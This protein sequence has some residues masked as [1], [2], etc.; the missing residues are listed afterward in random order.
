[1]RVCE[2]PYLRAA[3]LV[4][5]IIAPS[6][7]INTANSSV[8]F[9]SDRTH[10][11]YSAG[12]S[13]APDADLSSTHSVLNK[14]Y[15]TK[16]YLNGFEPDDYRIG[17]LNELQ[18]DINELSRLTI[19]N[20][21]NLKDLPTIGTVSSKEVEKALTIAINYSGVSE[22]EYYYLYLYAHKYQFPNE[23]WG[24]LSGSGGL[25]HGQPGLA[26]RILDEAL[27]VQNRGYSYSGA[28][29]QWTHSFR[30]SLG[31][32]WLFERFLRT[33]NNPKTIGK[34]TPY[35]YPFLYK[36][37]SPSQPMY[38]NKG[39]TI[40]DFPGPGLVV[41][42]IHSPV[43]P[44]G[45][46]A[47]RFGK[48]SK[49]GDI[50]SMVDS[51]YR[52]RIISGAEKMGQTTF[53]FFR[54]GALVSNQQLMKV[55]GNP[56]TLV[57]FND[58]FPV[59]DHHKV[60]CLVDSTMVKHFLH[61]PY[62]FIGDSNLLNPTTMDFKPELRGKVINLFSLAGTAGLCEEVPGYTKDWE[63]GKRIR[64]H[65]QVELAAISGFTQ[66]DL[67]REA[68]RLYL[69]G[70]YYKKEKDNFYRDEYVLLKELLRI[71][72]KMT[73]G[74]G[75]T[76]PMPV[77]FPFTFMDHALDEDLVRNVGFVGANMV[78]YKSSPNGNGVLFS[79]KLRDV[80]PKDIDKLSD[81]EIRELIGGSE[82]QALW[83][84]F[85]ES[86]EYCAAN[87]LIVDPLYKD[88]GKNIL[89]QKQN[90]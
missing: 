60:A 59:S 19:Y 28:F 70:Y 66:L 3:N 26:E 62:E 1:M 27:K 82:E 85:R 51:N 31:E 48:Q 4:K 12:M 49:A 87:P 83:S 57:I 6:N 53:G 41:F 50:A 38:K 68:Y 10:P 17:A 72:K 44:K 43:F 75:E 47:H 13:E 40:N 88:I 21:I 76:P 90:F 25:A 84:D 73:A 46:L 36:K 54:G 55:D 5:R 79:G 89:R 56:Y 65:D 15:H 8:G 71:N 39:I 2:N 18:A 7:Q 34:T 74:E 63:V 30:S 69:L 77:A 33:V 35:E 61:N 67:I 11:I 32:D 58:H 81:D 64:T 23:G 37:H 9:S 52:N 22:L 45:Y 16:D 14:L 20:K 42:G 24:R 78:V 29:N 80:D 86:S